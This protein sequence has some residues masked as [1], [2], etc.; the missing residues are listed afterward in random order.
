MAG[1]L[2]ARHRRATPSQVSDMCMGQT[3]FHPSDDRRAI[4]GAKHPMVSC[5]QPCIYVIITR[6]SLTPFDIAR[7][8]RMEGLLFID[9]M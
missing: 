5:D 7:G 1:Y 9:I 2:A 6:K 4:L 3:C 8:L